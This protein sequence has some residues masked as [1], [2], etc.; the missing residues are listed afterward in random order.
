MTRTGQLDI[1]LELS[2]EIDTV[3]KFKTYLQ[4]LYQNGNPLELWYPLATPNPIDLNIT[5]DLKLF[6]GVNNITNSENGNMRIRYV[7][8]IDSIVNDLETRIAVL[9]TNN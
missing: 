9:E 4:T 7:E 1:C 5:V 2:K 8:S 6:K 3:E